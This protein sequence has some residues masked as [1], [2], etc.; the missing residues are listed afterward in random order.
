MGLLD[1]ILG[2]LC[3]AGTSAGQS[4]LGAVLN[5]LGAGN[6][7]QSTGLL[8]VAMSMLQQHGGLSGV[9]ETFRQNGM[10]QHVESWVG[11]GPNMAISSE[12]VQQVFGNSA[13]GDAASQL[14]QSHSQA[15]AALAQLL[16]ELVN[17]LTPQGQVPSN[18]EDVLSKALTSLRGA[19]AV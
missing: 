7:G 13:I 3:G 15:S 5:N 8:T 17:H 4:S 14:G 1:G 19:P 18:I 12:Q 11:N 10:A 9:L 6:Q 2:S 16:P